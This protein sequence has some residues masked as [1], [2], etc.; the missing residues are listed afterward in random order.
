MRPKR[1]I[2]YTPE[3]RRKIEKVIGC[4][5]AMISRSLS[6]DKKTS[7]ANA[8]RNE[9]RRIGAKEI[10]TADANEVLLIEGDSLVW[11]VG[12]RK[13]TIDLSNKSI[14]SEEGGLKKK[15]VLTINNITEIISRLKSV[16]I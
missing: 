4:S 5:P 2:E 11:Q 1:R 7:L 15:D 13:V 10:I 14:L 16:A 3:I 6:Y 9:A 12:E 8:I